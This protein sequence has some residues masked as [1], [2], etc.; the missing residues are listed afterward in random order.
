MGFAVVS[1]LGPFFMGAVPP[2]RIPAALATA[3]VCSGLVTVFAG[4]LIAGLLRVEVTILL[5]M[6]SAIWFAV[7]FTRM[8]RFGEFLRASGGIVCGW[9]IYEM[10]PR[11]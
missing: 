1:L 6:V 3:D 2:R 8:N 4:V 9:L 11:I 10:L 7:H 5:P